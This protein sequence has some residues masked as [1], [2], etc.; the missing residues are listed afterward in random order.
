[1]SFNY[2]GRPSSPKR[3]KSSSST[4][5]SR[6]YQGGSSWGYKDYYDDW[7]YGS[8]NRYSTMQSSFYDLDDFD[9]DGNLKSAESYYKPKGTTYASYGSYGN[10]SSSASSRWTSRFSSYDGGYYSSLSDE[11][12]EKAR[13]DKELKTV[14]R[15][16]NSVRSVQGKLKREQDLIVRW[17]QGDNENNVRGKNEIHL[18]PDPL[19]DD[20]NLKND[21]TID[22]RRDV[23]IGEALALVGMKRLTTPIVAKRILED[24][25][26]IECH[27]GNELKWDYTISETTDHALVKA[28]AGKLWKAIEQDAARA[29]ILAEYRGSKP[30][31]AAAQTY[32]SDDTVKEGIN[33]LVQQQEGFDLADEQRVGSAITAGSMLSWNIN[34][35]L[36]PADSITP[37]DGTFADTCEAAMEYLAQAV[38][39]V[40]TTERFDLAVKAAKVLAS[41]EPKR[42]NP[43][44][45]PDPSKDDEGQQ[46]DDQE[47]K[48]RKKILKELLEDKKDGTYNSSFGRPSNKSGAKGSQETSNISDDSADGLTEA[49]R[50]TEFSRVTGNGRATAETK[51]KLEKYRNLNRLAL[52]RLK[53]KLDPISRR[54]YLPEHGLRRGRL[55][56]SAL[57]K[58]TVEM[59][60]N[61]RIFHRKTLQGIDR[62]LSIGLLV[63]FSGSMNGA[64]I[65][66]AKRVTVLLHDALKEYPNVDLQIFS[67]QGSNYNNTIRHFETIE[68][69]MA[70]RTGGGTD[71]G[72]AY[73]RCAK[74]MMSICPKGSRKILFALGDGLS[75]AEEITNAVNLARD[76]AI[77]TVDILLHDIRYNAYYGSA[78]ERLRQVSKLYGESCA[79]VIPFTDNRHEEINPDWNDDYKE[80]VRKNNEDVA[81]YGNLTQQLT[82]VLEPWLTRLLN[83]IQRQAMIA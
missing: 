71:E 79:S 73:A 80:H 49:S 32:Y 44:R 48:L 75:N 69:F 31:F 16:V 25:N 18:S 62:M 9:E 17:S 56:N 60:D 57:W 8:G 12:K 63:D 81:K 5:V 20:V 55:T 26:S 39:S 77:E 76:A 66:A 35:S 59:P 58:A 30:Y 61:D 1:M 43:A 54:S 74:E 37:P 13:M 51:Q 70:H 21:W 7:G 52:A 11:N 64:A 19:V 38:T 65:R 42:E 72:S 23:V 4:V 14:A 28:L 6:E 68:G 10:T 24:L 67:H 27:I 22:Q 29:T 47:T 15:S 83:R 46:P 53:K 3:K 50:Y 41:L 78:E 40:K 33:E 36:N 34:H 82:N 45:P 2:G